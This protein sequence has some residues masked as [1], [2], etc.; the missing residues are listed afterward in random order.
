MTGD[1]QHITV[2]C[3]VPHDILFKRQHCLTLPAH[4]KDNLVACC[5]A[6]LL[7]LTLPEKCQR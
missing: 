2:R 6:A 7:H 5:N 3:C 1:A 4:V